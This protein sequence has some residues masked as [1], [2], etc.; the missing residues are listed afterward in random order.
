M[1]RMTQK[2]LD[3]AVKEK[4][5]KEALLKKEESIEDK[6]TDS[7]LVKTAELKNKVKLS[8][9]EVK[10]IASEIMGEKNTFYPVIDGNSEKTAP[11]IPKIRTSDYPRI[12]IKGIF[13][14]YR[15]ERSATLRILKEIDIILDE[16]VEGNKNASINFL[17]WVGLQTLKGSGHKNININVNASTFADGKIITE[18][19]EVEEIA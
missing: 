1:G 14:S 10:I 11:L 17:M 9:S 13:P 18:Y 7:G 4:K 16:V 15:Q 12:K 3:E 8:D 19:Q 2:E 5:R 6:E